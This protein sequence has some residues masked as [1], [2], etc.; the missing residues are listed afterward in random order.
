MM[1]ASHY[2]FRISHDRHPGPE[3]DL[4]VYSARD[5]FGAW[6]CRMG[7][8]RASAFAF[9]ATPPAATLALPRRPLV[10]SAIHVAALRLKLPLLPD[11]PLDNLRLLSLP[12]PVLEVSALQGALPEWL[13]AGDGRLVD[14]R[15]LGATPLEVTTLLPNR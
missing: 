14:W 13:R 2:G 10:G 7:V 11:I 15:G 9:W 8:H 1:L 12:S 5:V 6:V 3:S 4:D